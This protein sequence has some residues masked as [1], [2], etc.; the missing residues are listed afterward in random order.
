M[1]VTARGMP[2]HGLSCAV[3]R[4]NESLNLLSADEDN[5]ADEYH[6]P[7]YPVDVRAEYARP[8]DG[9]G[10]TQDM[11]TETDERVVAL[12]NAEVGVRKRNE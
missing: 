6:T 5:K 1:T 7:V 9:E 8:R 4:R 12:L 11:I 2:Q 10:W 3:H